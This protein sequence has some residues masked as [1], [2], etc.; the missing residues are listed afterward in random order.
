MQMTNIHTQYI[1]IITIIITILLNTPTPTSI[2]KYDL[3]CNMDPEFIVIYEQLTDCLSF[4][5]LQLLV[6]F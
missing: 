2:H 3:T 6:V 1:I 4:C 5:T